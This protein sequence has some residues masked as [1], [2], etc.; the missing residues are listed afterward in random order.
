MRE[1]FRL[2]RNALILACKNVE[3]SLDVVFLYVGLAETLRGKN[4]HLA[5]EQAVE[6]AVSDLIVELGR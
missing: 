6:K 1:A 5:I 2:N 4:R 3:I